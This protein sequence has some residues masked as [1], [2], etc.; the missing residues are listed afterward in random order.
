MVV[1]LLLLMLLVAHHTLGIVHV[2]LHVHLGGHI[3]AAIVLLL[4]NLLL[5]QGVVMVLQGEIAIPLIVMSSWRRWLGHTDHS[6]WWQRCGSGSRSWYLS[7]RRSGA[8]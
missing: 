1:L 7:R 3:E 2:P 8:R 4:G 5:H 6:M